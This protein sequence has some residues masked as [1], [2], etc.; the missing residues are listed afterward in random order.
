MPYLTYIIIFVKKDI[1]KPYIIPPKL[2]KR[3]VYLKLLQGV[4]TSLKF[5]SVY[6]VKLIRPYAYKF[7]N[8]RITS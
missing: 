7:K 4:N 5:Y 6:A 8:H 3:L 1:F 2:Y